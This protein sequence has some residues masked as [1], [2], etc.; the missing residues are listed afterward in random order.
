MN[1]GKCRKDDVNNYTT[2][3]EHLIKH[4]TEE[5]S[6]SNK[7]DYDQ[8]NDI[9]SD[10]YQHVDGNLQPIDEKWITFRKKERSIKA[11]STEIKLSNRYDPLYEE[12]TFDD[13]N[14]Q[15]ESNA[16]SGD[17]SVKRKGKSKHNNNKNGIYKI[18]DSMLRSIKGI[19]LK[20]EAK[21]KTPIYV[22]CFP[23][24]RTD[25]MHSYSWPTMKRNPSRVIL[26]AGTNDLQ[27]DNTAL[28]IA[29]EIINLS[30][31]L[32]SINNDVIISGIIPRRDKWN[33][34]A[35]DV[36][37]KVRND[38]LNLNIGFIDHNNINIERDLNK[39]GGGHLN[40]E[41]TDIFFANLLEIVTC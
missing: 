35:K 15:S 18:G 12:N 26:H 28:E 36:N 17:K 20:K 37:M 2:V 19:D 24:A 4:N 5:S 29:N 38:C 8:D 40:R 25:C 39:G 31:K 32:K 16:E 13:V 27:S 33:E 11:N 21:S 10:E 7:R 30:K 1:L 9:I 23:G 41:G 6:V 22:K 3:N 34:K 14:I